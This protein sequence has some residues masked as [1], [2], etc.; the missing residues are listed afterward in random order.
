MAEAGVTGPVSQGEL[1]EG[2]VVSTVTE[3]LE[4]P[5]RKRMAVFES[6]LLINLWEQFRS[7][8]KSLGII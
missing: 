8:K 5:E 3:V 7:A 1:K 6:A 4:T 2:L